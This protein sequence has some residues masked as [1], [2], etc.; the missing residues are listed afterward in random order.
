MMSTNEKHD[1]EYE[2]EDEEEE[3]TNRV[4]QLYLL[5]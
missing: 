4:Y 3:N 1:D 5:T 2:D